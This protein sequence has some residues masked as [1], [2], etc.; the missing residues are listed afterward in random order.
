MVVFLTKL[1]TPECRPVRKLQKIFL[2]PILNVCVYHCVTFKISSTNSASEGKPE[3]NMVRGNNNVLVTKM[4]KRIMNLALLLLSVGFQVNARKET[5]DD[6][7]DL[8]KDPKTLASFEKRLGLSNLDLQDVRN[9]IQQPPDRIQCR[10]LS[11]N[12]FGEC[13]FDARNNSIIITEESLSRGAV[14][15]D[16][17][18]N[19]SCPSE[20]T[21]LCCQ[22]EDCD[23]AVYQ[24][25]VGGTYNIA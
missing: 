4:T 6:F 24:D 5:L 25:K 19:V 15:V 21:S 1:R 12:L 9:Q 17:F 8:L 18:V 10:A 13:E 7:F 3:V 11:G 2:N 16:S 23:T 20:C 22:N 14:F